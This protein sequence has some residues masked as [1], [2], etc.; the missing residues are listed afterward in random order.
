MAMP[1]SGVGSVSGVGDA[2][3]GDLRNVEGVGARER[4]RRPP[5]DVDLGRCVSTTV[6]CVF[7]GGTSADPHW[8]EGIRRQGGDGG[9]SCWASLERANGD[10]DRES[11]GA[12]CCADCDD[13]VGADAGGSDMGGCSPKVECPRCGGAKDVETSC[14]ACGVGGMT[15]RTG[16]TG[17]GGT[18]GS[19]VPSGL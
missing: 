2:N 6:R 19:H 7:E 11:G 1:D 3:R 17:E 8:F 5:G 4:P 16:A 15:T 14:D 18:G 10:A 13:P 9:M 12:D